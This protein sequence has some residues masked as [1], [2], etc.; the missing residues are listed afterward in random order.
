MPLQIVSSA[1]LGTT[2][3]GWLKSGYPRQMTKSYSR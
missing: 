2:L 1:V 3:F